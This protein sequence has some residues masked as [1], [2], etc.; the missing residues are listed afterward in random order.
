MSIRIGHSP[1]RSRVITTDF[2]RR[3]GG[4][5]L[6][7][8]A[9]L[10][11]PLLLMVGFSV[12]VGYWYNRTA[13]IQ[14]AADAAA[15]AGVVWLPDLD[16]AEDYALEA[17][18]RNGFVDGVDQISVD[19]SQVQGNEHQLRVRI[20]DPS[21]GSYFYE[22]DGL[23]FHVLLFLLEVTGQ[24]EAYP[25]AGQRLRAWLSAAQ[26]LARLEDPS[27]REVLRGL[28]LVPLAG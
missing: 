9:L 24:A 22:K 18:A 20:T 7:K 25:E 1:R 17:A 14:K 5:V 26:A 3:Q 4:F 27:L 28:A 2:A 19:V 15:L 13:A 21:V 23:V 6:L 10:L 12:D 11:V 16:K 8:F